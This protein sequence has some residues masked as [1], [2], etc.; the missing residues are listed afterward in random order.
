MGHTANPN[1]GRRPKMNALLFNL[2]LHPLMQRETSEILLSHGSKQ[3]WQ[4]LVRVKVRLAPRYSA[5]SRGTEAG[6]TRSA[7]VPGLA[8]PPPLRHLH[9]LMFIFTRPPLPSH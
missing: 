8:P 7:L 6:R 5:S 4:V 2:L 1:S 9:P 3:A